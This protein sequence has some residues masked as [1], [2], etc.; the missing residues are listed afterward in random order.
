MSRE[1]GWVKQYRDRLRREPDKAQDKAQSWSD[2]VDLVLSFFKSPEFYKKD[3]KR[4]CISKAYVLIVLFCLV[5]HFN[6]L[7]ML[8]VMFFYKYSTSIEYWVC[9]SWVITVTRSFL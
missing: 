4:Q 1:M 3:S 2:I 7:S 9:S 8:E 6:L 5:S